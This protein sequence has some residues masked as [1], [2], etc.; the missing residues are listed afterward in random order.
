MSADPLVG[1]D[2]DSGVIFDMLD[3]LPAR[4]GAL[5]VRGDAGIGKSAL[6]AQASALAGGS[7]MQV[8]RATGVQSEANLSFAG[9][10]RL[11][12]PLL[13]HID[14]LPPH[15]REALMA[16]FGMID[17]AAPDRFRIALA[18][19]DVLGD[20]ATR[21]PVVLIAEDAQW[22]DAPT[23]DV[24][25][26]VGRRLESDPIV[27]L[28]AMRD[29]YENSPL[30]GGLPELHLDPLADGFARA[31][32]NRHFPDLASTVHE[33]VLDEAGGNPLALL[34]LPLA[35]ESRGPEW[36]LL[37]THL[38][39]TARLEHAFA[40]RAAELPSP[41]RTLLRIAAV[42][43]G[44]V[45]AEIMSAA[46][47][48]DGVA[49]TFEALVPAVEAQLI[50]VDGTSVRFRHP[51]VRSAIHQAASVAER[52]TAH[53]ALAVV[54]ADNPD[55][56]VWH[57]AAATIGEDPVVAS[58]LEQAA[59]RAQRRGAGAL[60]VA[61]F[62]RATAF[63]AEPAQRG[64]LLL[65]AAALARELGRNET[66]MRLLREADSLELGSRD[67]AR[68]MWLEESFHRGAAGDPSRVHALVE[69][70]ERMIA[71]GD[72]DLALNLLT[73]AALKCFRADPGERARAE[74]VL[75]AE[76]AGVNRTDPRLLFIQGSAA[77]IER[78]SDVIE[79]L[80]S[81]TSDVD[82]DALYLLGA[83]AYA[84]GAMD[85]AASLL[86]RSVARLREQGRLGLLPQ[87][88]VAQAWSAIQ[89]ADWNVAI[90]AAEEAG[91]LARETGQPLWEA[92]AAANTAVVA[93]LRG[94]P[95]V[96]TLAAKAEAVALPAGSTA[97]LA[98]VQFAR[99]L[100]A[101]GQGD[102]VTA[103]E[104]LRRLFEPGDP[105]HHLLSRC[106]A[107]GD[108]AE[109]AAHSGKRDEGLAFMGELEPL[110]R[111]TPSPWFHVALLYARPILG[112]EADAESLFR[113]AL[114]TDLTRWP[115]YRARLQLAF[116][117]W[118][119][120]RRRMAESRAPLR[121]ARDAFDALGMDD[122]GQR[123]RQ[124]LRASGES[125]RQRTPDARDELTAQ[126]LQI[127][128][129]AAGGLS[130]REIGQRLYLSHR[131]VESHL[132]RVFPKLGVTSRAQLSAALEF[133]DPTDASPEP[134]A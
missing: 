128:Q 62:E 55:R 41:T 58:E 116:G 48:V 7:G 119:R 99:G 91:R 82:P 39:L 120:R 8:L 44:D 107:I 52:H 118:L 86:A 45:L 104:H 56:R 40:S 5:V 74:V 27:L 77:T 9:L 57:R 100:L 46:E 67:R 75:A 73:A 1:R 20:A 25:A 87:V 103:Y 84:V 29:G 37:P 127:A 32:L 3:R 26:F 122:W 34:E 117:E 16:A 83:A 102:H 61:A 49:P 134:P 54:L 111:Q 78:G 108:L 12:R 31:L 2:H 93:A 76:R 105:A 125:S 95:G 124:E 89:Q 94:Q 4:G 30:G 13:P 79:G 72:T 42:D 81:D 129:L 15:Q 11:L 96:E 33:R 70:A 43:D 38:P 10:H 114:A 106:C 97:T 18:A 51:L 14:P 132:Y 63:T 66:V 113:D 21:S 115:L 35:L 22:L 47:I 24:L 92:G 123:A 80:P 101:L 53:A 50:D 112:A 60:A 98:A 71:D 130:N 69:T 23:A 121:A 85:R 6:L 109:A 110:A 131:T 64:A 19:L 88:L 28:A 36:E 59:G 133:S 90:P 126:E 68:S 17:G 65:R